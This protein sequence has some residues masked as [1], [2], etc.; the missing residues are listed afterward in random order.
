MTNVTDCG[1]GQTDLCLEGLVK[2]FLG[3]DKQTF[4]KELDEQQDQLKKFMNLMMK[5]FNGNELW[6]IWLAIGKR[7]MP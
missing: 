7:S 5:K 4:M 6:P 3:N 1:T 2:K